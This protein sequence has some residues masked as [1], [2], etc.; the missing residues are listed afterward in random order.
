MSVRT[1]G[2]VT[3]TEI[4]NPHRGC[5][6]MDV[7]SHATLGA[8][9]AVLLTGD[10]NPDVAAQGAILGILPDLLGAPVTEGYHLLKR[11]FNVFSFRRFNDTFL[12]GTT[13]RWDNLPKGMISYYYLLHSVWFFAIFTILLLIFCPGKIWWGATSYLSHPFLDLFLHKDERGRRFERAIRPFWP[14]NFSFQIVQWSDIYLWGRMPLIP[15]VIQILFWSW[16]L[17][18]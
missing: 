17:I 2:H 12:V 5:Q 18:L 7:V 1:F 9:V 6:K 3:I 15:V 14:M 11:K 13:H 8:A 10:K 4:S 16:F